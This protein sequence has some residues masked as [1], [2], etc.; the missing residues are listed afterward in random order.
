MPIFKIT[1]EDVERY[2]KERNIKKLTKS[3]YH[4]SDSLVRYRAIE[5]LGQLED[6]SAI[7]DILGALEDEEEAVRQMA[8]YSLGEIGD[9]RAAD[10]II[11]RLQYEDT[12]FQEI[13]IYALGEIGG[14]KAVEY[15]ITVLE[16]DEYDDMRWRAAEAL[17]KIGNWE[18]VVPLIIALKDRN[19]EVRHSAAD[20]LGEIGAS[21]ST[22]YLIEALDDESWQVRKC[23]LNSLFKMDEISFGTILDCLHDVDPHVREKAAQ[24]MGRI[25]DE[26][27][28]PYLE[29]MLFDEDDDVQKTAI[30]SLD[31]IKAKIKRKTTPREDRLLKAK[32]SHE[33]LEDVIEKIGQEKAVHVLIEALDER[34]PDTRHRAVEVLGELKDPK[35]VAPLINALKD[36]NSSVQWR[37][38]EALEKIKEP[39]VLPL[40]EALKDEN[41]GVRTRAAW[42]LGEIRDV[43][44]IEPLI[45]TLDDK[46]ATVRWK[47][48]LSL[49]KFKTPA[50]NPLLKA[51]KEGNP[52]VREKAAESLGEIGDKIA[53]ES[54][55]SALQDDDTHVR[56]SAADAIK[57]IETSYYNNG[58]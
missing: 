23:S 57:K 10:P 24:I 22:E 21:R 1:E 44:A 30:I 11:E 43:R 36:E 2:K 15:L 55:K 51:L 25:D 26:D 37:A 47:S 32:Q 38:S 27:F 4:P 20:A 6:K 58:N 40:I 12:A 3:I 53:I 35:A 19:R 8:V 34:D 17:G 7:Y 18:S 33:R 9:K 54:L 45:A 13:V 52:I 56:I 41:D 14:E 39:A 42:S 29:D 28:I 48:A 31:K 46:S 49:G 16:D 50:I 5:A